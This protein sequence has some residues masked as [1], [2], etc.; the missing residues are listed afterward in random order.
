MPHP[1]CGGYHTPNAQYI[2]YSTF[3]EDSDPRGLTNFS[4]ISGLV[5][6]ADPGF[7]MVDRPVPTPLPEPD[8][9]IVSEDASSL[10]A[11]QE[12]PQAIHSN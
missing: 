9:S 4:G 12:L 8:G 1:H 5:V 6:V 11:Y 3:I 7:A 2:S 10:E